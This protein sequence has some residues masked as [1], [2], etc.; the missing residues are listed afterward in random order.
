MSNSSKFKKRIFIFILVPVLA[1]IPVISDDIVIK[2]ITAAILVIYVGLIIFL[3]DSSSKQKEYTPDTLDADEILP[4]DEPVPEKSSQKPEFDEGEE[5]TIVKGSRDAEVI[6]SENYRPTFQTKGRGFFKPPDLKENFERIATE[7]L[8]PDL[9]HD[10][11]FSFLLEKILTV[12]KDA[13][14]AHTA[15]FFWYNQ[16][17]QRFT[18]EKYISGSNEITK[19]K[20]DLE[21]DILSK[22]IENEEPELLTDIQQSAESDVIRYYSDKQGIKSFVGVPLFYK[23]RLTGILALDSKDTDAFG[24]ETIYSLGRFVRVIAIVIS[25]FEEKFVEAYAEQRLNALLNV[26]SGDKKFSNME[27]LHSTIE[28]AVKKLIHWD[29]FSFVYFNP[30]KQNFFTSR[31]VNKTSLKYAGENLTVELSGTLV[32]KAVIT[33]K[34]VK[35]D[36]TSLNKGFHRFTQ[37]DNYSF[38]GSFLAVPLVFDGQNYGVLC[39]EALKKNAYTNDDVK[40]LQNAT[41]I[42]AFIVYSY[43]NQTILKSMIDVDVETRLLTGESLIHRI[44]SDLA[45]GEKLRVP[46]TIAVIEIDKFSGQDS[47]FEGSPLP[48][49]IIELTAIL[50]EE[51]TPFS[52]AGR[53]GTTRFAVYFFNSVSKDV[54]LWAE[55]LRIKIARKTITLGG[56]QTTFTISVGVSTAHDE[57]PYELIENAELALQKAIEVG[58]NSVKSIN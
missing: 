28:K 18:L 10:E 32:G 48:K 41:Q 21:D 42:F 1:A 34:P 11:Q 12:C 2:S 38:D 27:E 37:N 22:I 57:N 49:I 26:L 25:L 31:I 14:L 52:I 29:A 30:E 58:G 7:E 8:P 55:K 6:T 39:F 19:Q 44:A 46:S 35:I 40:F 4:G 23:N 45:K 47:L 9:G 5:F 33:G 16:N 15:V 13:F 17:K 24:I 3:R 20:F 43:S 54:F 50:K 56:K 51:L 53:L 36:D